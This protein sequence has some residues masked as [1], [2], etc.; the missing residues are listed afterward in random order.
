MKK[1]MIQFHATLEELVEYMNFASS[2][3]G[4][5]MTMMRLK[6][7][8][9]TEACTKFL[10]SDLKIEGTI[11]IIFTKEN[12]NIDVGSPNDFYDSNLGTVGLHIGLMTEHS[13]N[14]SALAFMS[15]EKEKIAFANKLVS[16]LKKIT[17]S[18]A[19]AVNPKNGAEVNVRSHRYTDGAKLIYDQGLKILPAAGNSLY[20]L[21]G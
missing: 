20:K 19:T 5:V 14:E 8:T 4:L 16:R 17:K 11:R 7:F 3:L 12:P 9:L 10:V 13:L 18:G 2:E 21:H 6:P 1:I 15:D